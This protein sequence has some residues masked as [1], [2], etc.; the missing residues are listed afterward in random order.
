MGSPSAISPRSIIAPGR[1]RHSR[2][3][4]GDALY[5]TEGN[6]NSGPPLIVMFGG[7]GFQ[8]DACGR[9]TGAA[10]GNSIHAA[11]DPWIELGSLN[12]HAL[13]KKLVRRDPVREVPLWTMTLAHRRFRSCPRTLPSHRRGLPFFLGYGAEGQSECSLLGGRSSTA[14]PAYNTCRCPPRPTGDCGDIRLWLGAAGD[15]AP[16]G[17]AARATRQGRSETRLALSGGNGTKLTSRHKLDKQAKPWQAGKGRLG[18]WWRASVFARSKTGGWIAVRAVAAFVLRGAGPWRC[19][20]SRWP[21]WLALFGRLRL[22]RRRLSRS[23][24][25]LHDGVRGRGG[26]SVAWGAGGPPRD[27]SRPGHVSSGPASRRSPCFYVV[28]RA[29]GIW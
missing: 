11:R 20:G 13:R 15:A 8:G 12:R 24:A 29:L 3:D 27:R 4:P 26:N 25:G 7:R 1:R 22:G 16:P 14:K 17:G 28:R 19:R 21:P 10:G 18:R 9:V 5:R 23:R 6:R 2:V